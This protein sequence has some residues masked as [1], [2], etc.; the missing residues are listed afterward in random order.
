MNVGADFLP[1]LGSSKDSD[2]WNAWSLALRCAGTI[3]WQYR[4][5]VGR[6]RLIVVEAVQT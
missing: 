3:D 4:I 1:S 6:N 5:E 2:D